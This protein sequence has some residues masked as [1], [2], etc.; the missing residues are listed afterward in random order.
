[1]TIDQSLDAVVERAIA[2]RRIVGAVLL[3][4]KDGRPLYDEE[5]MGL[6]PGRRDTR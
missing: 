3:V 2:E 1:M 6:P 4:R 5:C